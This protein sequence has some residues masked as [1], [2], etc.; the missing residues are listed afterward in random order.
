[1][2]AAA[3]QAG[4]DIIPVTEYVTPAHWDRLGAAQRCPPRGAHLARSRSHHLLRPHDRAGRDLRLYRVPR[5]LPGHPRSVTHPEEGG[6][7]RHARLGSPHPT[8]FPEVPF[9]SLCRGCFFQ[10]LRRLSRLALDEPDGGR[11]HSGLHGSSHRRQG[12]CPTPSCATAIELWESELHSAGPPPDRRVGF[13]RQARPR[14]RQDVDDGL[15]RAA[16]SR[17]KGRPRPSRHGHAY[18]LADS[19]PT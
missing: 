9:G 3:K 4:L 13:G 15:R 6:G 12:R 5:R 17:A 8:I 2:V 19:L 18:V 1:M 10:M 11:D 7:R 16:L 14:L